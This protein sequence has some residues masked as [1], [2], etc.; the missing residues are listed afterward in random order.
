MK[1]SLA[2]KSE[3][4]ELETAD[5]TVLEY[6]IKEMTGGQRDA[7]FNQVGDKTK[8]AADGSVV[9][10]KNFD[11]LYSSLLSKTVYDNTDKLVPE[12]T[13]QTWPSTVQEALFKV[14]QA[15]NGL[16][17]KGDEKKD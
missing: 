4:F 2:R 6:S 10:M 15:L 16:E 12:A 14:A 3:T 9:G 8:T 5:G 7:Y 11:G 17:A 13:L 1:F